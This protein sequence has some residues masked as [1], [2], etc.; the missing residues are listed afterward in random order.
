[1]TFAVAPD[2]APLAWRSLHRRPSRNGVPAPQEPEAPWC[3]VLLHKTLPLGGDA[4]LWLG[5][6]ERCVAWAWIEMRR[7][8]VR[9]DA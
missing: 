6:F 2:G 7:E 1:M 8:Q 4:T 5:D 3:A 9:S